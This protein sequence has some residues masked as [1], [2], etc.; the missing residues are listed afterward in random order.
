MI[1]VCPFFAPFWCLNR[2]KPRG[3]KIVMY[4]APIKTSN[5][6]NISKRLQA[7]AYKDLQG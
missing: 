3:Y 5:K 2:Y 7:F 4:S 1:A 6:G